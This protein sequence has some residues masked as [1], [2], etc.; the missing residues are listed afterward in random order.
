MTPKALEA[1]I[2]ALL[3]VAGGPLSVVQLE[4][5]I[6]EASRKDI[7]AAL[8]SLV[9]RYRERGVVLKRVAGGY[10][11]ETV[12]EAAPYIQRLVHGS[13]PKLSR[14]ALETLAIVAYKQPITKAEIE[15]IRG[16]DSS[17]ALRN[18]MEKDLV[19]ICGRKDIP[20]RPILY[21]TTAKFLEIF[22]L[23]DLAELPKL[24]ELEKMLADGE[25]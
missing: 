23:K 10:R 21:G 14:A 19:K 2:E 7:E 24:E 3:F 22:G 4:K 25:H 18:L 11:L 5:I 9:I 13:P 16:V 8:Q 20:G 15:A 6:P 17:G 1:I 12:P